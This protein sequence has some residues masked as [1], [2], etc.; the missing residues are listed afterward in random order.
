MYKR[1][2]FPFH[3]KVRKTSGC[4]YCITIKVKV[5]DGLDTSLC[6]VVEIFLAEGR[7]FPETDFRMV[8]TPTTTYT[9][10]YET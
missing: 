3:I 9:F 2:K 4:T 8:D 1:K 6:M 5:L 10:L 7:A